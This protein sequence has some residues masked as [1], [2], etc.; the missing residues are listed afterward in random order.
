[1]VLSIKS[2]FNVSF[3][4]LMPINLLDKFEKDVFWG[5]LLCD[6]IEF[7]IKLLFCFK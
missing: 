6:F 2:I 1:M 3:I 7:L 4:T 5:L